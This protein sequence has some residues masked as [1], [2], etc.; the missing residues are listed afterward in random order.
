MSYVDVLF[1]Y[2]Y[3]VCVCVCV[4]SNIMRALLGSHLLTTIMVVSCSLNMI[5][6]HYWWLIMVVIL[7]LV[8]NWLCKTQSHVYMTTLWLLF[9]SLYRID[10]VKHSLLCTWLHLCITRIYDN[11]G[12]NNRL[13]CFYMFYTLFINTLGDKI[14]QESLKLCELGF[15]PVP[16]TVLS[17]R[18]L[19]ESFS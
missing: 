13:I 18:A 6:Y 10:Y 14:P 2:A 15:E 9:C 4:H 8:Q 1:I 11:N 19:W 12:K 7:F 16:H 5:D 3:I 17:I